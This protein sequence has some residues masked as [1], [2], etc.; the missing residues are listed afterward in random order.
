MD[1]GC[2]QRITSCVK[3]DCCLLPEVDP[4]IVNLWQQIAWKIKVKI[5]HL[6]NPYMLS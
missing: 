3:I 4:L 1:I 6:R 5:Y 2:R